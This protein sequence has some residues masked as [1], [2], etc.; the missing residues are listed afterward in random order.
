MRRLREGGDTVDVVIISP[1]PGRHKEIGQRLLELAEHPRDV[2]WVS[3]PKA[4]FAVPLELFEA[5]TADDEPADEPAEAKTPRKRATKAA[6]KQAPVES[7]DT[8]GPEE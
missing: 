1:E 8:Q 6:K 2:Q 5:F 7:T 4:G 3:W